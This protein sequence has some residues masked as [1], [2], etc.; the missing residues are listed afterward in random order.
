[1]SVCW[2][3]TQNTYV[4][5]FNNITHHLSR[6]IF[7][8]T[9]IAHTFGVYQKSLVSCSF[10]FYLS[11]TWEDDSISSS[12]KNNMLSGIRLVDI[13]SWIWHYLSFLLPCSPFISTLL[14]LLIFYQLYPLT[15]PTI[16]ITRIWIT[17]KCGKLHFAEQKCR[18]CKINSIALEIWLLNSGQ[19]YSYHS[20][21]VLQ[22]CTLQRSHWLS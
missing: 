12:L 20:V 5:L 9:H 11:I 16:I 2:M 7:H 18:I 22:H 1:M 4:R 13:R 10:F 8:H 14:Y 6:I 15:I 3:R 19:Y 17:I 21:C